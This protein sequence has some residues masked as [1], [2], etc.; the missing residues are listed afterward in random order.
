MT[1]SHIPVLT[2]PTIFLAVL[3][4]NLLGDALREVLD[5]RLSGLDR[6]D[7]PVAAVRMGHRR[8]LVAC[9]DHIER[10]VHLHMP[11]E[12]CREAARVRVAAREG[13]DLRP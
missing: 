7:R 3:A 8:V 4:F 5:P 11:V 10:A 12:V 1:S 6:V 9:P 2:Y 13:G